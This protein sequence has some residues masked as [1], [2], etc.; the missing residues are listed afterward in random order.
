MKKIT[1]F[2]VHAMVNGWTR[3][4]GIL[5]SSEDG[6]LDEAMS[7]PMTSPPCDDYWTVEVVVNDDGSFNDISD[8]IQ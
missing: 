8:P 6:A 1:M 3:P 4:T 5:S 2:T 7:H